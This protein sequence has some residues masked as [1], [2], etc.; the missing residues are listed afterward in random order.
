MAEMTEPA[1]ESNG[2]YPSPF[3][4]VPEP[5]R[6][7]NLNGRQYEP[8]YMREDY[9]PQLPPQQPSGPPR[10]PKQPQDHKTPQDRP[11]LVRCADGRV[12]EFPHSLTAHLSQGML[13]STR[14]LEDEDR[15][16]TLME[17]ILD[18]EQLK[19]LDGLDM[20]QFE[21]FQA[22]WDDESQDGI[23]LGESSGSST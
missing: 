7:P 4:Q 12:V 5:P 17:L 1:T 11:F 19:I 22:A 20:D 6:P 10:Q 13:R 3:Y 23:A 9:R 21:A 2:A 18:E 16:W 8:A 15:M 14:R